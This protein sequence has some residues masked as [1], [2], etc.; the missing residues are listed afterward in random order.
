MF[1]NGKAKNPITVIRDPDKINQE[2]TEVIIKL[3]TLEVELLNIKHAEWKQTDRKAEILDLKEGIL[4]K[5][6]ELSQEMDE[7]QKEI[8]RKAAIEKQE[9]PPLPLEEKS[10]EVVQ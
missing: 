1:K 8:Q 7:S 4:T 5:V 2:Y 10:A 6:G 9:N 3:G